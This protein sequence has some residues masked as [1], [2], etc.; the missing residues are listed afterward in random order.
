MVKIKRAKEIHFKENFKMY[1]SFLKKYKILFFTIIFLVLINSATHLIDRLLFKKIVDDGSLFLSGGLGI[2]VFKSVL[3]IVLAVYLVNIFFRVSAKWLQIHLMNRLDSGLITDLKRKFF[4]HIINLSHKFHTT[5]KTGSMISRITRGAGAIERM[6]DFMV[7]NTLPLVF[8]LVIVGAALIYFDYVS[9]I[10][11]FA[12]SIVFFLFSLHIQ[13]LQKKSN[14]ELNNS[15]DIEKANIG[16]FF[17]NID[18]IRNFGKE[19]IIISKYRK[20]S[21]RSRKAMI[22]HWGYYKWLDAG[23]SFIINAGVLLL[24]LFPVLRLIQ[25]EITI[26]TL[27]FIYTIYGNIMGPLYGFVNGMRGFYRSMADFESLFSYARIENEVKDKPNAERIKIERGE[28]EFK[29]ISFNYGKRSIFKN[30][31]LKIEENQKVA[32]VGH[33]GS[34]K[35]TLVKLLYRLYDVNSGAILIDGKDIRDVKQTSL[36]EELSIVPQECVLFDDTIYNNIAFSKPE[37][38]R[39]EVMKAIKFAQLDKI[40]KELP[41]KENTIVGER[42]VKLSGGE[43]QRVSIARAILADKKILV[44]DEATSSLDSRTEHEIQ[45]D[46]ANLMKGRTS[47]IIAH[48]LSTIMKAD[49]IV[50]MDKGKIVQSGKHNDLIRQRGLYK[51]LWSLQKGGYI[52]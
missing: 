31:S 26:G 39:E 28:V 7:F 51:E 25:G 46:L 52:E 32:L 17:T 37:A 14:V 13:N 30:F 42:G 23:H 9:A 2:D 21:E 16:D 6:T 29:N 43:K 5:H 22:W 40:I 20:L 48:R 15:E 47:I 11:V 50:V 8:E 44:L 36:R 12:V 41:K 27:V 19:E 34:G 3:L 45:K 49:K 1:W 18:S 10:V 4:S 33:S 38:S 24:I 35:T